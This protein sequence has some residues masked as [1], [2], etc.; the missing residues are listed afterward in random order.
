LAELA[1]FKK[2]Q[3]LFLYLHCENRKGA[4]I[5]NNL[6]NYLYVGCRIRKE[7]KRLGL[8]QCVPFEVMFKVVV[9]WGNMKGNYTLPD[10]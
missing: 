6:M 7:R 8:P 1:S 4:V 2:A 3:S 5:M 10:F 9:P